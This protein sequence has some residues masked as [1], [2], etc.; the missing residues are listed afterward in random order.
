MEIANK[1]GTDTLRSWLAILSAPGIGPN[2][3]ADIKTNLP[4]LCEVFKLSQQDLAAFGLPK[5]ALGYLQNPDW[6]FIDK[7]LRWAENTNNHIITIDS[8]DYPALLKET[9][10]APPILFAC[11]DIKQLTN[12]QLAVIGSRNP[13]NNGRETAQR[14]S[15]Y[16]YFT[17][18]QDMKTISKVN[19]QRKTG[20]VKTWPDC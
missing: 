1:M 15:H 20:I 5:S 13:T 6:D 10:G 9:K 4:D 17:K 12:P 11:G 14:F 3:F 7:E 8:N 2:K 19:W 18:C 16:L